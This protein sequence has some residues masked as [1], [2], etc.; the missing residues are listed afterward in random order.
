MDLKQSTYKSAQSFT[1]LA[2][3]A[4]GS[5]RINAFYAWLNRSGYTVENI[6]NRLKISEDELEQR[7]INKELF[8]QEQIKRLI[9][10]MGAKDAFFAI[11]FSSFAERERIYE[12]TFLKKMK[13]KKRRRGQ[14]KIE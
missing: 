9:R 8:D 1:E 10:L 14:K 6:A 3:A 4:G 7:L 12:A 2:P 5:L 11:Y 13:V